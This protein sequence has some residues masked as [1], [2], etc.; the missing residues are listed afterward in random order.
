M[1]PARE[2]EGG[3]DAVARAIDQDDVVDFGSRLGN[4]PRRQVVRPCSARWRVESIPARIA[5]SLAVRSPFPSRHWRFLLPRLSRFADVLIRSHDHWMENAPEVSRA[6]GRPCGDATGDSDLHRALVLAGQ[7]SL[8]ARRHGRPG[9]NTRPSR[10]HQIGA[11]VGYLRLAADR[12]GGG[13]TP[14]LRPS[15]QR[16]VPGCTGFER[17]RDRKITVHRNR[18][19]PEIS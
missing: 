16:S 17:S 3:C 12:G 19:T 4:P 7:P 5:E 14:V 10:S 15:D 13:G 18:P 1:R 9:R 8:V 2:H 11:P 6:A